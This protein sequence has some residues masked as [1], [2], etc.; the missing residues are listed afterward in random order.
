MKKVLFA[1]LFLSSTLAWG[2]TKPEEYTV[3][4]HVQSSEMVSICN[5]TLG[6]PYCKLRQRLNVII[7]GKKYELNSVDYAG[8]A[9]L[10]GDYKAKLRSDVSSDQDSPSSL[11]EYHQVYE[12][13]F[14]NGNTR[15]Y[16]VAGG[17]E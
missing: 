6:N 5:N 2:K 16:L 3:I 1:V 14:P 9:L 15:R 11:Y 13:L 4:V 10:T 17:S 7:D 12:F 8:A